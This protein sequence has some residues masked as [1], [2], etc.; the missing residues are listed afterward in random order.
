MGLVTEPAE[1][2]DK[3]GRASSPDAAIPFVDSLHGKIF[4]NSGGGEQ[5][6]RLKAQR[7]TSSAQPD[8]GVPRICNPC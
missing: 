2:K 5:K 4:G 8:N 6:D 3:N 1:Q 7:Q